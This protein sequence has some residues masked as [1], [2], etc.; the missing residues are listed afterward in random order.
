MHCT[1][2]V[3]CHPSAD[4]HGG[5]SHF[6]DAALIL[7]HTVSSMHCNRCVVSAHAERTV[8]TLVFSSLK[9]ISQVVELLGHV[10][11]PFCPLRNSAVFFIKP[12]LLKRKK[13]R[14]IKFLTSS[15]Q[16]AHFLLPTQQP[17]PPLC[18]LPH[19]T[20]PPSTNLGVES[21]L[22]PSL[23][24]RESRQELQP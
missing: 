15:F 21:T 11:I 9:Q 20:Q 22:S 1:P 8:R 16:G 17:R 18:T 10:V 14:I 24:L 5:R 2:S 12:F 23:S 19:T 4:R 7:C 6:R 3:S 13:D